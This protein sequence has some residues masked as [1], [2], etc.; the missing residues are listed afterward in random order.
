MTRSDEELEA[1]WADEELSNSGHW[2]G[3]MNPDSCLP[4]HRHGYG[5]YAFVKIRDREFTV[6]VEE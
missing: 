4:V 3:G 6:W 1:Q 5:Q 2:N